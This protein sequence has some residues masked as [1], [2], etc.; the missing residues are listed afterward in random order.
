MVRGEHQRSCRHACRR[1]KG[2][3]G[4]A[5]LTHT[6]SR[7]VSLDPGSLS[8][9][10]ETFTRGTGLLPLSKR[11]M[12]CGSA[13]VLTAC[14]LSVPRSSHRRAFEELHVVQADDG[15]RLQRRT[16]SSK[17]HPDVNAVIPRAAW[18]HDEVQGHDLT[19]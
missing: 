12:I 16:A 11:A 13:T 18:P 1:E 7:G 14:S 19:R 5:R 9:T 17:S 3:N 10:S 4:A 15:A 6:D 8:L 2:G